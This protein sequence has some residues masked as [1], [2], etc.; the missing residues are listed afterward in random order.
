M[1]IE[2]NHRELELGAV[3]SDLLG[4][5][6]AGSGDLVLLNLGLQAPNTLLHDGHAFKDFPRRAADQARAVVEQA[7]KRKAAFIVHASFGGL[8][9][10]ADHERRLRSP[11]LEVVD[12]AV[13]AEEIVLEC[14]IPA[15]VVRLGYLYG[16]QMR[17]LLSY[18]AAFRLRRPYWAGPRGNLQH[19]LHIEDAATALI[20]VARAMP[21]EKTLYAVD[22]HPASFADFMD[23]FARLVGRGHPM[24]IPGIL[25][26]LQP[27]V[28]EE[29]IQCLELRV[30]GSL[31]PSIPA[32]KPAFPDHVGGLAQTVKTWEMRHR[33]LQARK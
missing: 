20:A 5:D 6:V 15:A 1:R 29:H 25:R 17:D 7:R 14:G 16:P 3:V 31:P 23:G 24:H 12:A 11:L 27:V 33:S 4:D 28:A 13:R 18:R 10:A 21:A 8:L 22:E 19:H 9:R 30:P 2:A 26:H 32:W